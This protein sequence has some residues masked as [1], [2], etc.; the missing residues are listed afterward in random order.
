[1]PAP[2]PS[3]RHLL[4]W[5]GLAIIVVVAALVIALAVYVHRLLQPER[6]TALLER[7]LATAGLSL[8]MQ[9]PAEPTLFPRPAVQLHSFSLTN[10]GSDTPVLQAAGATIVVPWRALLHGEVAIERIDVDAPHMD[11]G[12]LEALLARLPQHAA[13]PPRLP[14]IATGIE[15]S[16][17][18][19][20]RD[21]APLLF[22]FSLRTGPLSPRQ[23]FHVD[24]SA[25]TAAGR[26]FV[27]SVD[28]VP[29]APHDG[30]IAFDPLQI[31]FTGPS[32]LALFVDGSGSW[33]GG[34]DLALRLK[35]TLRHRPLAPA[36]ASSGTAATAASAKPVAATARPAT[37]DNVVLNVS[38]AHGATPVS[39][40]VKLEGEDAHVDM[41]MRPTEFGSWWHQLLAATP[42]QA[43]AAL[44]FTGTARIR[45]LDLDGIKASGIQID[46][47]PDAAP[48]AGTSVAPAPASG[49]SAAPAVSA[50]GGST[51]R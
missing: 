20:T 29:S 13:G 25:R 17:G 38:P 46:A 28:T 1:M 30:A 24:A 35:G 36:A 22:D 2:A 5:I 51:T 27:A 19:L 39:V 48:A 3:S 15:M 33:R 43:P 50:P 34:E 45:K 23:A 8:D 12:E 31:R 21:G 26:M 9:Q 32:D 18:T 37:T 11:L 47:T 44:P 7:D 41:R 4:R 14:T 16:H 42:T 49:A 6:F 40:A 10:I